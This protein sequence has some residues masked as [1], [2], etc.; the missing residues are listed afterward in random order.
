MKRFFAS[1]TRQYAETRDRPPEPNTSCEIRRVR[2]PTGPP[3]H[4][5]IVPVT[6][7]LE[8]FHVLY[9]RHL[10]REPLDLPTRRVTFRGK[11]VPNYRQK[12]RAGGVRIS[13][14]LTG[15][16]QYW[17]F[18]MPQYVHMTGNTRYRNTTFDYTRAEHRDLIYHMAQCKFGTPP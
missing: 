12:A 18:A 13:W 6:Q 5:A 17:K 8:R 16:Q 7:E 4:R 11:A 1:P 15:M 14:T 9:I 10:L 2:N 3:P